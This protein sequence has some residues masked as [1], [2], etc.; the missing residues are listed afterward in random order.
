MNIVKNSGLA[1]SNSTLFQTGGGLGRNGGIPIGGKNSLPG[2]ASIPKWMRGIIQEDTKQAITSESKDDD[3]MSQGT[4][5]ASRMVAQGKPN[6]D[7]GYDSGDSIDYDKFGLEKFLSDNDEYDLDDSRHVEIGT[8]DTRVNKSLIK[9]DSGNAPK[10][11]SASRAPNVRSAS[12]A[13]TTK[14]PRQQLSTSRKDR[15]FRDTPK[16]NPLKLAFGGGGLSR[17]PYTTTPYVLNH[18]L[19]L[20]D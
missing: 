17:S 7:Q 15:S 16:G 4:T 10:V 14:T 5:D 19:S 3:V 1:Q 18:N 12:K 13:P 6:E 20:Y 8:F 11:R 2:G 9:W